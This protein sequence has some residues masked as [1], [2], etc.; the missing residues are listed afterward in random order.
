[1]RHGPDVGGEER[2]KAPGRELREVMEAFVQPHAA[3]TV[4]VDRLDEPGA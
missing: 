3:A 4:V 2:L 1:M